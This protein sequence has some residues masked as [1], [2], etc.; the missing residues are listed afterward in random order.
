MLA[1]ITYHA[2]FLGTVDGKYEFA[3]VGATTLLR[4]KRGHFV[5]CVVPALGITRGRADVSSTTASGG[6]D[7]FRKRCV[8]GVVS[9]SEWSQSIPRWDRPQGWVPCRE[10]WNNPRDQR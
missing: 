4:P 1:H 2:G 10:C 9:A 6:N 3:I 5:A 7:L 8:R